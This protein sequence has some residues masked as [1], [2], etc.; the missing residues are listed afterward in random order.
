MSKN[1]SRQKAKEGS[2]FVMLET[3]AIAFRQRKLLRRLIYIYQLHFLN[4][5]WSIMLDF[6]P[7]KEYFNLPSPFEPLS[8]HLNGLP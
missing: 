3:R 7:D 6:I 2:E 5:K 1:I 4:F 8:L